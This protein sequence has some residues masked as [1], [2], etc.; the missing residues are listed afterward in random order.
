M[1]DLALTGALEEA[2]G[3]EAA[4]K[5]SKQLKGDAGESTPQSGELVHYSENP[6]KPCRHCGR[7]HPESECKFRN[8][9]CHR[10]GKPGHIV[11]M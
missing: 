3:M 4:E 10:C 5:D 9:E 8:A 1:A 6:M 11:P 2:Q 7:K